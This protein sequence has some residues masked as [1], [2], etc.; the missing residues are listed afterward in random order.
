MP[1][2]DALTCNADKKLSPGNSTVSHEEKNALLAFLLV[3]AHQDNVRVMFGKGLR[4]VVANAVSGSDYDNGPALQ[5]T[6]AAFVP[7]CC[8]P[9]L[10]DGLHYGLNVKILQVALLNIATALQHRI[11]MQSDQ[12]ARCVLWLQSDSD[13]LYRSVVQLYMSEFKAKK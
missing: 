4:R 7:R 12:A 1:T 13:L 10:L 3:S 5:V 6:H 8:C 2:N 9:I 11:R